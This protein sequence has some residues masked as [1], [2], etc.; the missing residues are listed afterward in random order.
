M[1]CRDEV[2]KAA[3]FLSG[4]SPDVTF[5]PADIVRRME[6]MGTSF[7]ESTIRTHVVSK[8]CYQAPANHAAR[9]DDLERVTRGRYRLR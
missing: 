8:M 3:K 9:Y 7:S 1:T 5:S 6:K 2:L 4:G